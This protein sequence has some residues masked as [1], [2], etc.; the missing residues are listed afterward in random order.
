[1]LPKKINDYI[2]RTTADDDKL[3]IRDT[4]QAFGSVLKILLFQRDWTIPIIV[5]VLLFEVLSELLVFE[6]VKIPGQFVTALLNRDEH[7]FWK[8]FERSLVWYAIDIVIGASVKL[9]HGIAYF[10]LRR[11][12]MSAMH[13]KYFSNNVYYKMNK[14]NNKRIDNP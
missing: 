6:L 2:K 3:S 13:E 8:V 4:L 7:A 11:N 1:M 12:L 5:F 14:I 9:L 10:I